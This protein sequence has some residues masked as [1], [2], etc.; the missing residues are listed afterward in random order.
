MQPPRHDHQVDKAHTKTVF[1]KLVCRGV[2][3]WGNKA[4]GVSPCP[5]ALS[6]VPRLFRLV[7]A[8][9][10]FRAKPA[11]PTG[12]PSLC[13]AHAEAFTRSGNCREHAKLEDGR[14]GIA[15]SNLYVRSFDRP[16]AASGAGRS[17]PGIRKTPT[18]RLMA[19]V[20]PLRRGRLAGRFPRE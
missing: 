2:G 11:R 18:G 8:A 15:L 4:V 3:E 7:C 6:R 1:E 12:R 9:L 5:A 14:S 19:F 13:E 17:T 20:S 16:P 10:A